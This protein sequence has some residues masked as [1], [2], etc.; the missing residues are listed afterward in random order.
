MLTIHKRI[1]VIPVPRWLFKV[2]DSLGAQKTILRQGHQI[3]AHMHKFLA[4]Y[5]TKDVRFLETST[6]R[7]NLPP[8]AM[9]IVLPRTTHAWVDATVANG[10]A[11]VAHFHHG[12]PAHNI[13]AT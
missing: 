2:L 10:C 1:L 12:H 8:S 9:V 4:I 13:S 3:L 7:K 6:G 11:V 5:F